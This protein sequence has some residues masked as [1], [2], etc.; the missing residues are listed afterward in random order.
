MKIQSIEAV[1][2]T[3][4]SELGGTGNVN[5]MNQVDNFLSNTAQINTDNSIPNTTPLAPSSNINSMIGGG[6]NDTII[7]LQPS[8]L[9][10]QTVAIKPEST[11]EQSQMAAAAIQDTSSALDKVAQLPENHIDN[12]NDKI[13]NIRQSLGDLKQSYI[14]SDQPEMA[15]N[16]DPDNPVQIAEELSKQEWE[17]SM[18]TNATKIAIGELA[19]AMTQL[20]AVQN[21]VEFAM[22]MQS[23]FAEWV[24]KVGGIGMQRLYKDMMVMMGVWGPENKPENKAGDQNN[25]EETVSAV[26]ESSESAAS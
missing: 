24:N 12:L 7:N 1:K 18:N 5:M 2:P 13:S 10:K 22:K 11:P 25:S 15:A 14:D 17:D 3:G 6:F 16:V 21:Y 8:V 23:E 9:I 20:K 19:H 4:V 26:E